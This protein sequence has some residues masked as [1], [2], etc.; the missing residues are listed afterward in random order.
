M[1]KIYQEGLGVEIDKE[2][3]VMC[4]DRAH[5]LGSL[6]GTSNFVRALRKGDG[7]SRNYEL[8]F[9]LA[10][11]AA[12]KG[13][14]TACYQA[15]E[16]ALKGLGTQLDYQKARNL[17]EKGAALGNKECIYMLGVIHL[18]GYGTEPDTQKSKEHFLKAMHKGHGWVE[19][20]IENNEFS[21]E[22]AKHQKRQR[23]LKSGSTSKLDTLVNFENNAKAEEL[24]GDWAGKFYAYDWAG[25]TLDQE[26]PIQISAQSAGEELWLTWSFGQQ[27]QFRLKMIKDKNSWKVEE[28]IPLNPNA[29]P[30]FD[31]RQLRLT[32]QSENDQ[33]IL[34]GNALRY[35][36]H[37]GDR[38]PPSAF[39]LQPANVAEIQDT[40]LLTLYPN[41]FDNE[42]RLQIKLNSEEVLTLEVFDAK[43]RS[44]YK[45]APML[46]KK[47]THD[48][49]IK[50]EGGTPGAYFV[51]VTGSTISE[52]EVIIKKGAAL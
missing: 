16:M 17:F 45:Q 28:M 41:P 21:K 52:S 48:V 42:F 46:F 9:H 20:L 47:G 7:T 2:K 18:K 30:G 26:E 1:G 22:E 25:K 6:H 8:A 49:P 27:A 38:M 36:N 23:K 29:K 35:S 14:P 37:T 39:A 19:D 44:V 15:G 51:H 43:G 13:H 31:F 33:K 32:L 4:Y 11:E 24:E 34:Y 12:E 5:Q 10:R 50:L 40:R 3:A